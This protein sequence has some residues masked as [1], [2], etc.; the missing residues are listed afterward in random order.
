MTSIT[1]TQC[2]SLFAVDIAFINYTLQKFNITTPDIPINELGVLLE[3]VLLYKEQYSFLGEFAKHSETDKCFCFELTYSTSEDR[4]NSWRVQSV[5]INNICP[6]AN[7]EAIKQIDAEGIGILKKKELL[8][9]EGFCK[10]YFYTAERYDDDD[11]WTPTYTHYILIPIS[12]LTAIP[13]AFNSIIR[14]DHLY[15]LDYGK[16]IDIK[17]VSTHKYY[18][19]AKHPVKG[20]CILD[21]DGDQLTRF[22]KDIQIDD[23]NSIW[24]A[25]DYFYETCYAYYNQ[26][27]QICTTPRFNMHGAFSEGLCP[28]GYDYGG[29]KFWGF[30]NVEGET[31]IDA[32]YKQVDLDQG[33][34]WG[35]CKVGQKDG[36]GYINKSGTAVTSTGKLIISNKN[37]TFKFAKHVGNKY[38][39]E[40]GYIFSEQAE[41]LGMTLDQNSIYN[42]L[43]YYKVTSYNGLVGYLND[44]Y[45]IVIPLIYADISH[46]W[47]GVAKA[48]TPDGRIV[49]L[50]TENQVQNITIDEFENL[51]VL[52]KKA[53]EEEINAVSSRQYRTYNIHFI[54]WNGMKKL[55]QTR[56]KSKDEAID[57]FWHSGVKSGAFIESVD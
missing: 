21:K 31:I 34:Y 22:Y 51:K 12:S 7:G 40:N 37:E 36:N 46:F 32:H 8:C 55:Y 42:R 17:I 15:Y 28:I 45:D 10:D 5:T 16:P 39:T 24:A 19:I 30:I 48:T 52:T 43:K 29:R 41:D 57:N 1:I 3:E 47:S 6:F 27:V 11:I 25:N 23:N 44:Q 4:G 26:F 33:F 54:D 18:N 49:F 53:L 50:N 35:I 14:N 9:Y 2:A 38:I 20:Y 13:H 56:A